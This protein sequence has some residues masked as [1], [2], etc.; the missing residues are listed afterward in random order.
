MLGGGDDV[1]LRGVRHDDPALG[2]GLDVDVVHPH[3]G[4]ADD[5]ELIGA[6]EQVGGELGGR[7]D[8]D[9]V[10]LADRAGQLAVG[11][12]GLDV[13]VEAGV[14]QQPYP[15]VADL[16]GDQNLRRLRAVVR[17]RHRSLTCEAGFAPCFL[18]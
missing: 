11:P 2:G 1:G 15:R 18:A 4:P 14:L 3:P 6:L 13:D 12:V 16:L 9:A 10:V 17:R 5:L 8:Q 7:A